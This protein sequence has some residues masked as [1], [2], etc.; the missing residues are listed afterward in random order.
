M[1]LLAAGV[2]RMLVSLA[3]ATLIASGS[4]VACDEVAAQSTLTNLDPREARN[5]LQNYLDAAGP[6][7]LNFRAVIDR[8]YTPDSKLKQALGLDGLARNSLQT[9]ANLTPEECRRP[10]LKTVGAA[11]FERYFYAKQESE[12]LLRTYV[13]YGNAF[14]DARRRQLHFSTPEDDWVDDEARRVRKQYE[15]KGKPRDAAE[16]IRNL[17]NL[18]AA[19]GKHFLAVNVKYPFIGDYLRKARQDV[20][21]NADGENVKPQPKIYE[22]Q[23]AGP[24]DCPEP[25]CRLIRN[26][27]DVNGFKVYRDQQTKQLTA[28]DYRVDLVLF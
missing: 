23:N 1:N 27:Y 6:D 4:W 25:I 15:E 22:Q 12:L 7:A 28:F 10:L 16:A 24:E 2:R 11:E 3:V 9:C 19:L 21:R 8:L 13:L 20:S 5:F 26:Y 17:E 14:E 18:N